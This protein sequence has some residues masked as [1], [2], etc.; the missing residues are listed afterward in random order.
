MNTK[1]F[2][3]KSHTYVEKY[4]KHVSFISTLII[5]KKLL[6]FKKI[7]KCKKQIQCD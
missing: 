4:T 6:N 5:K 2:K 7:M 1:F 3:T